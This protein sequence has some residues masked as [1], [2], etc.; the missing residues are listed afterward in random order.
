MFP[1]IDI[2]QMGAVIALATSTFFKH[3]YFFSYKSGFKKTSYVATLTLT[4][5]FALLYEAY[6]NN[7]RPLTVQTTV[8]IHS[9]ICESN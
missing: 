6:N 5:I 3:Y 2:Q 4:M 8:T 1:P 7:N 9:R